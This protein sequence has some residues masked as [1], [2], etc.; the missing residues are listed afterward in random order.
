MKW[1]ILKFICGLGI[2]GV[3]GFITGGIAIAKGL[4]WLERV[5]EKERLERERQNK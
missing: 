3:V 2:G 4:A 1:Q 5:E